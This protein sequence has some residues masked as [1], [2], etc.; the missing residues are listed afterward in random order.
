MPTIARHK[1]DKKDKMSNKLGSV[2]SICSYTGRGGRQEKK[3]NKKFLLLSVLSV[4]A[5]LVHTVSGKYGGSYSTRKDRNALRRH[6]NINWKPCGPVEKTAQQLPDQRS[7]FTKGKMG[8]SKEEA[9]WLPRDGH[10]SARP[11]GRP[12]RGDCLHVFGISD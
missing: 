12:E 3:K 8:Q 5:I 11:R 1:S 7:T 9:E 4:E 10:H 6:C 2:L